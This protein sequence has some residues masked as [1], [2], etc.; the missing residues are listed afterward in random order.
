MVE[1]MT[2]DEWTEFGR[3]ALHGPPPWGTLRRIYATVDARGDEVEGLRA[4]LEDAR[5]ELK[6]A[7]F[8][9]NEQLCRAD[10]GR[11]LRERDATR[12]EAE[13]VELRELMGARYGMAWLPG[14]IFPNKDGCRAVQN[15]YDNC[16]DAEAEVERLTDFIGEVASQDVGEDGEPPNDA[17]HMANHSDARN[18][19]VAIHELA[20][21]ARAILSGKDAT[22]VGQGEKEVERLRWKVDQQ[23]GEILAAKQ[24]AEFDL[25]EARADNA[26]L[27]H[28]I[29]IV[30]S[31]ADTSR[32]N[33][34]SAED[35]VKR[36]QEHIADTEKAGT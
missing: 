16:G 3:M 10:N 23:S 7:R 26:Q 17:S 32:K 15:L 36:L 11:V 21:E 1:P 19:A 30:L 29:D 35:E 20:K 2:E 13:L 34:Q 5:A 18:L 25:L 27:Q 14:V 12:A 9:A 6:D 28:A 4:D 31:L 24:Q 33:R 8:K 22:R